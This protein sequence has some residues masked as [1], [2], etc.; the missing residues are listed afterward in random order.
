MENNNNFNKTGLLLVKN[1]QDKLEYHIYDSKIPESFDINDILQ[2]YTESKEEV[3]IMI[4]R[5][6]EILLNETGVLHKKRVYRVDKYFINDIDIEIV[7]FYNTEKIIHIEINRIK[8]AV[9][10]G[11]KVG[12]E[13]RE[14]QS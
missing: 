7:L 3:K 9:E 2:A 1:Y 14:E 12:D 5:N 4:K 11:G 13:P 8:D 10:N 6:N